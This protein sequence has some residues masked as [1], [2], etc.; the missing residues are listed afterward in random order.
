[1]YLSDAEP[2]EAPPLGVQPADYPARDFRVWLFDSTD[3]YKPPTFAVDDIV[4]TDDE[5]AE[6]ESGRQK[7]KDR[8]WYPNHSAP[9]GPLPGG[10]SW[11]RE[12]FL[13][14]GDGASSSTPV[15]AVKTTGKYQGVYSKYRKSADGKW[16]VPYEQGRQRMGGPAFGPDF[17]VPVVLIA[18][19]GTAAIASGA[20]AAGA[21][22]GGAGAGSSAAVAAPVAVAP[23][24]AAP[25]T[26]ILGSG[27]TAGGLVKGAVAVAPT[28]IKAIAS[29]KP[30]AS[31]P[32]ATPITTDSAPLP[33]L[34]AGGTPGFYDSLPPVAVYPGATGGAQIAIPGVTAPLQRASLVPTM[35]ALPSWA[36]PAGLGMLAVVAAALLS[37][38]SR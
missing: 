8:G 9:R 4:W 7:V 2:T 24:A 27:V 5:Y 31:S 30:N 1:M 37:K 38:R 35:S 28:V 14:Q 22:A 19:M 13:S 11:G 17:W 16:W 36:L 20:G 21:A 12:F 15:F 32:A 23:V 18:T 34:Y 26:G 10:K 6:Y 29:P 33:T 3:P 25:T